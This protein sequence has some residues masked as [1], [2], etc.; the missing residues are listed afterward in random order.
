M[1]EQISSVDN[2]KYQKRLE[3]AKQIANYDDLNEGAKARVSL[4][5]YDKDL[6]TIGFN[7][8]INQEINEAIN[9][10]AVGK[11][12]GALALTGIVERPT[13]P[14]HVLSSLPQ[15]FEEARIKS[16]GLSI[17]Q[18]S[19]KKIDFLHAGKRELYADEKLFFSEGGLIEY[20]KE[21]N[22]FISQLEQENPHPEIRRVR[23]ELQEN[24]LTG[25]GWRHMN[26][27]EFIRSRKNGSADV[28]SSRIYLSPR[29]GMDMITVFKEVFERAEQR[30]LRFKAKIFAT[31]TNELGDKSLRQEVSDYFAGESHR[32]DP[33]LFYPFDESKDDML[34]IVTEVY[35]EHQDAFKGARTGIIPAKI[36][37]GLAVGDEPRGVSG[38]ESLTSHREKFLFKA[39][40]FAKK[41]PRWGSASDEQKRAI[42]RKALQLFATKMNIDPDNIAFDLT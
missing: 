42:H 17:D 7:E 27:K 6:D 9:S 20:D 15:T 24:P 19:G 37:P 12:V 10:K 38:R 21:L 29:Y 35:E 14:E 26:S 32:V 5:A 16:K 22:D 18:I 33:M 23:G 25:F 28:P 30:G 3:S 36:A 39:Q 31:S 4:L 41:H 34:Q 8:A 1:S 11:K 13:A 2:N 40:E